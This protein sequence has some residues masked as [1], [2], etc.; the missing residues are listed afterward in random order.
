VKAPSGVLQTN[1][2]LMADHI[3]LREFDPDVTTQYERNANE[4]A[5]AIAGAPQA[6]L[7]SY[8]EENAI[9]N[10]VSGR[11]LRVFSLPM[12]S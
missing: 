2:G 10:S 8:S 1:L 12:G 9:A 3:E 7:S 11:A 6:K 4:F 5:E